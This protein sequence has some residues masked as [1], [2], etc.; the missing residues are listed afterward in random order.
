MASLWPCFVSSRWFYCPILHYS[1]EFA[2]LGAGQFLHSSCGGMQPPY[3]DNSFRAFTRKAV[4]YSY[5]SFTL[6]IH[7]VPCSEMKC[8]SDVTSLVH[9]G[10]FIPPHATNL[11]SLYIPL[12]LS[13][14]LSFFLPTA[15]SREQTQYTSLITTKLQTI[16]LYCERLTTT[17]SRSTAKG[18]YQTS[19]FLPTRG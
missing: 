7:S 1:G 17:I 18:K 3:E 11:L 9:R 8:L 6:T 13:F 14:F 19:S 16:Y 4:H 15:N 12:L 2:P 5:H 10:V